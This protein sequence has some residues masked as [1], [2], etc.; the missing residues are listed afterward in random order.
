MQPERRST[1]ILTALNAVEALAETKGWGAYPALL[2][3]VDSTAHTIVGSINAEELPINQDVWRQHT[4]PGTRFTLPYWIG[5]QAITDTLTTVKFPRLRAWTRE[6]IGPVIAM[7]FL[8]EGL[9]TSDAGR[10]AAAAHGLPVDPDGVPVRAVSACDI[11]GRFYQLLRTRGA[12]TVST[13]VDHPDARTS[14]GS[15]AVS[16]RRLLNATH[17]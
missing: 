7:A 3:L 2:A 5:L 11:D 12:D 15:V 8:A 16:L 13:T 4:V 6:Q 10:R 9:D 17:A 14:A 1:L